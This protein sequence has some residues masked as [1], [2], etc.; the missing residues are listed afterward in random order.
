MIELM[1]LKKSKLIKLVH[2]KSDICH[3][4]W[5]LKVSTRYLQW[6]S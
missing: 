6:V 5:F 4:W 3:Y 2:Q 1:F